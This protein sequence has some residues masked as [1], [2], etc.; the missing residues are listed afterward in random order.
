MS[1]A[2]RYISII[3]DGNAEWAARHGLPVTEGYRA[4]WTALKARLRDGVDLGIEELSVFEPGTLPELKLAERVEILGEQIASDAPEFRDAGISLRF[5]GRR[6]GISADLAARMAWAEATTAI[7][8]RLVVFFALNYGGRAE[9]LDAAR[10]FNAGKERNLRTHLYSPEMHDPDL[11]IRTG[12]QR[13]LSNHLVWQS[14]YSEL[15]FRDEPWP[16]FD[17]VALEECLDEFEARQRRFG[18]R[19]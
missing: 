10:A 16:D 5:I 1:V 19:L 18:T 6:T 15:V 8:G 7:D 9:I 14:A 3:A 12:G 11:L 17:R 13:R 4:G 2:A